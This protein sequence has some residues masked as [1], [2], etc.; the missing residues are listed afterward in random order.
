VAILYG[1]GYRAELRR[2]WEKF[3]L[4][5]CDGIHSPGIHENRDRRHIQQFRFRF[6]LN[7]SEISNMREAEKAEWQR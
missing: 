1:K 4:E 6:M 2:P 3:S 7:I 5:C